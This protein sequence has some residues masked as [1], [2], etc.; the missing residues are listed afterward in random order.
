FA[1]RAYLEKYTDDPRGLEEHLRTKTPE[2]AAAITGLDVAEIETFAHLVGT[3]KKTYFRLGYGFSRQRNGSVNMHAAAS[4]AAVTG[5]WQYEGGG[6]FHSNS[7]IFKLN[8][9]V[10]EGTAM[11]DPNIRHL[12]HSRIGPVLTGASDALYGGPP[13]TALLIQNTNPVNVAPEQRLVKQGFLRDDLFTCVHEQ[14]MTDTARLADVV[15]P[16]TMFL[17]HD[18]IYKG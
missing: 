13:V 10:L 12:D 7:G 4:I 14:F 2:W 6:A 5:A 16:A 11:R 17:E 18:D 8:Q 1:D 9:D 3:T 15:L